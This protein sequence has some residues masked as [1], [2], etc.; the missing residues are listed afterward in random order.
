VDPREI[1][2]LIKRLGVFNGS[3]IRIQSFLAQ[4][5]RTGDTNEIRVHD[6]SLAQIWNKL[7]GLQT[8]LEVREHEADRA[9]LEGTYYKIKSNIERLLAPRQTVSTS[10]APKLETPSRSDSAVF[11]DTNQ[12]VRVVTLKLPSLSLPT[13]DGKY[14]NLATIENIFNVQSQRFNVH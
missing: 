6:A 5:D 4:F 7:D 11:S 12:P 2:P 3:L 9:D 10:L 8:L 13:F 1:Q 14:E